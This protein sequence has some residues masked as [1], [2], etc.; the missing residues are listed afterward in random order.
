MT[1]IL[2]T[3]GAG[4]IGSHI[5]EHFLKTTD[6]QIIILD[7]LNHAGNLNRITDTEIYQYEKSR[8]KFYYHDLKAPISS[9]LASQI[10][11]IDVIL[12]L[13][14]GTHVDDSIKDPMSFVYDNVV[15]TTNLLEYARSIQPRQFFYFSTDEVFGP[16]PLGV[17]YKE[18]DRYNSG[19]PY[20]A[21]KAGAEEMC[22]AY[23]NTFKVPVVITHCMNVFGERQHP[24]KWVPKI[25]NHVL[26][27][28][29]LPIHANKEKTKA[30]TRFY[31]HARNVAAAVQFLMEK[32]VWPNREQSAYLYPNQRMQYETP[33]FNIVGEREVSN[34][35]MALKVAEIMG[36]K[37]N[38][39]LVDFHSSRPG[40]DLRYALDGSLMASMGWKIPVTFEESLRKTVEWTLAH[41]EWTKG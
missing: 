26:S 40:H 41:P 38:Y 37:L 21:S 22:L 15:G 16:A 27:G 1:K 17:L 12:H 31:I 13:G 4:F 28:E 19:N 20:S 9:Q 30:G 39:E 18:W 25:I 5:V 2:L 14:A 8:V 23:A 32:A 33:K 34:L 29:K 35:D 10:G 6:D 3:G 11:Q 36:K 7:K 24:Q